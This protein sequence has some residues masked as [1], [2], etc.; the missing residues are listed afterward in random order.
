MLDVHPAH[1]AATTWRDFFIHIATIVVGL[2][3]AVG[4]E[5]TVE[6]LHHT[7]QRHELERDLHSETER[8]HVALQNNFHTLAIE[9]TWLLALRSDVDAMRASGG[10]IKLPYRAK[11]TADPDSPDHAHLSVRWPGDAVWQ[12]AKSSGLINLL[13]PRQAE[14]YAGVARQ[15]DLFAA[16]TNAWITEQTALIAFETQFDDGAPGSTP[17]LARMSPAQL[18]QYNAMLTRNLAMR[19]TIVNRC[20]IFDL[21][22]KAILDGVT[23]REQIFQRMQTENLDFER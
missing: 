21:S 18:D 7:H 10:K 20:K 19:D 23:S 4:L 8:Q 9:R 14:I 5:Q 1:H 6:F 16:S 22:V 2:L 15:E 12:T 11:P 13:P 3:I 17:D